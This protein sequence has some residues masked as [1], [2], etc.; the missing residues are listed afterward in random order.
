MLSCQRECHLTCRTRAIPSLAK[1]RQL[2][3]LN[4]YLSRKTEDGTSQC[5]YCILKAN[6]KRVTTLTVV[7]H[8]FIWFLYGSSQQVP[9]T[10]ICHASSRFLHPCDVITAH[11]LYSS[12]TW[13]PR[14][15]GGSIHSCRQAGLAPL[16]ATSAANAQIGE[17]L[18]EALQQHAGLAHILAADVATPLTLP[19]RRHV[20]PLPHIQPKLFRRPDQVADCS[21][22]R[23]LQPEYNS[24]Y[25]S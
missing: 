7:Q 1:A 3:A 22:P 6:T 15:S 20:L 21:R 10:S 4:A 9:C 8:L 14:P 23:H 19:R 12:V 11:T 18:V 16:G 5:C 25:W 2:A 13:K 17:A 24:P